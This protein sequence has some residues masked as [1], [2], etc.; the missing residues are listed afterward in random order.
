MKLC[1][2]ELGQNVVILEVQPTGEVKVVEFEKLQEP[3]SHFTVVVNPRPTTQT[4][5]LP[6]KQQV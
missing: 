1:R 5:P 2:V 4:V 3:A 6:K